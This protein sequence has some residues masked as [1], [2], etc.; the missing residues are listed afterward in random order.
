MPFLDDIHGELV[1]DPL[2]RGYAGMTDQQQLDDLKDPRRDNW[3]SLSASQIFEA[4][5]A[6]E[7]IGLAPAK[8]ARVDRILGLGAE[9]QTAPGSQAR[10]ELISIFGGSSTSITNLVAIANQRV[11]R[12]TEMGWPPITLGNLQEIVRLFP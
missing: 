10:A 3:V 11:S 2:G 6:A 4:I 8:K 9:I 5:D 12:T 1:N 7:F